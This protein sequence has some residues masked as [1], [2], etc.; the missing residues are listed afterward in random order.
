MLGHNHCAPRY[1]RYLYSMVVQRTAG[2][3][4]PDAHLQ[5]C[6][7]G[8]R[9]ARQKYNACPMASNCCMIRLTKIR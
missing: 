8:K 4:H 7:H 1:A 2:H 9:H 3:A 5:A 6:R